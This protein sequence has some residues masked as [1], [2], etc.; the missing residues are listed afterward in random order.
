M[1]IL[2]IMWGYTNVSNL[3]NQI[4]YLYL[5]LL[6][7]PHSLLELHLQFLQL[8]H[9][10]I[11]QLLVVLQLCIETLKLKHKE[12]C[13]RWEKRDWFKNTVLLAQTGL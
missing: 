12:T 13:Y 11:G 3:N 2:I 10:A 8:C 6:A 1:I 5:E 7:L 4:S 9:A